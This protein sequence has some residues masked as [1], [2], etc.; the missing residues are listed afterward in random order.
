MLPMHFARCLLLPSRSPA[1]PWPATT[2]PSS[3]GRTGTASRTPRTSPITW[4]ET[5]NVRWK[6]PVHDK[7][8]SSP[9]V[10]G[11]QVWVTTADEDG[12][13]YYAVCF[14]RKDGHTVH[15]LHL[16]DEP[17]PPKIKQFNSF[18]SPTPAIEAGR[19]YAHFG[20]HGTACLDTATGKV[21][22][23]RRDLPCNHWRGPASSVASTRTG[24]SSSSTGT[25]GSTPSAWRRRPARPSG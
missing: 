14:D 10:W 24:S 16:F 2:G 7:G 17:N 19:F 25:T 18:A 5:E 22:W 12:K 8:W 23:Q 15:D 9:V 21:L 4:S 20:S 6:V 1:P 11:D 3:A 13:A